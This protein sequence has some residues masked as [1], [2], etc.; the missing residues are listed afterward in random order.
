MLREWEA[1]S[2]NIWALRPTPIWRDILAAWKG[3]KTVT[4]DELEALTEQARQSSIKYVPTVRLT[5]GRDE[6]EIQK[7]AVEDAELAARVMDVY[8]TED[9]PFV[10]YH[11][12]GAYLPQTDGTDEGAAHAIAAGMP[13]CK[14]ALLAEDI[15][16]TNGVGLSRIYTDLENPLIP[17]HDP[18]GTMAFAAVARWIKDHFPTARAVGNF[19]FVDPSAGV[20]SW[21]GPN[22][23]APV[24]NVS[25][26]Q[27]G[28]GCRLHRDVMGSDGVIR[29]G[30]DAETGSLRRHGSYI[31]PRYQL[32]GNPAM[33]LHWSLNEDINAI[34]RLAQKDGITYPV[35]GTLAFEMVRATDGGLGWGAEDLFRRWHAPLLA[36]CRRSGI[37]DIIWYNEAG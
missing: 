14:A 9:S 30:W 8:A 25:C 27:I 6:S 2:M 22:K 7:T 11:G 34:Q 18:A 15:F 31:A 23:S 24:G 36:Q 20:C 12:L 37:E 21:W 19:N 29:P 26:P 32:L 35:L 13:L 1:L 16:Y 28:Y 33:S 10:Q 17:R 4:G 5:H 3:E